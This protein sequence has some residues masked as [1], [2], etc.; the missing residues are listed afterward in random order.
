MQNLFE[1]VLPLETN[2]GGSYDEAHETFRRSILDAVG[3]YTEMPDAFGTRLDGDKLYQDRVRAYRV[4]CTV[5]QWMTLVDT[6][7]NLFSDQPA[8]FHAN[9]GTAECLTRDE[10]VNKGSQVLDAASLS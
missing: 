5:D 4:L 2:T 3:G 6:A 1:I 7:F 9:L 8:I 10:W